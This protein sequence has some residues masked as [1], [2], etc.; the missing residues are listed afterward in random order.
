MFVKLGYWHV[1][2]QA[3]MVLWNTFGPYFIAPFVQSLVPGKKV[4][5]K[6]SLATIEGYFMYIKLSYPAWRDSLCKMVYSAGVARNNC[7][8]GM[9]LLKELCEQWIPLV[10]F[11]YCLHQSH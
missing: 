3:N 7:L 6:I 10:L 5:A 1:Y 9:M 8:S 2:K 11:V 4:K